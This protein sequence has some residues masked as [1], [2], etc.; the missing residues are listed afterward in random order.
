ME[1]FMQFVA[2]KANEIGSSFFLKPYGVQRKVEQ[3]KAC[4]SMTVM[5]YPVH[6]DNFSSPGVEVYC[7]LIKQG[8][9]TGTNV[10][11]M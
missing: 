6:W 3:Y 7:V 2:V 4:V 10:L 8:P 1:I 11:S 5:R 9:H